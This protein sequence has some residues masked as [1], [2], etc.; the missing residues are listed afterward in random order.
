M[1]ETKECFG[2]CANV[3]VRYRNLSRE[4]YLYV[5]EDKLKECDACPLFTRCMF[6]RYNEVLRDLIRLIDHGG[7]DEKP[8]IG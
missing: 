5:D 4:H 8:K 6:L 7:H 2:Q 1:T 3:G